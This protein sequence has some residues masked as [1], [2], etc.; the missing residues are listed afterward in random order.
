MINSIQIGTDHPFFP[1]LGKGEKEWLSVNTN[2]KAISKSFGDIK[3]LSDGVL[4]GNAVRVL[5]LHV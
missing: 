4:G 3:E 1:P 2:Y 5:N